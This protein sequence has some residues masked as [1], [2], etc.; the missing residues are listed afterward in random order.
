MQ[1]KSEN[2]Q[3]KWRRVSPSLLY[4]SLILSLFSLSKAIL[5]IK[6]PNI[7]SDLLSESLEQLSILSLL[8]L[9]V[10]SSEINNES[11]DF[12]LTDIWADNIFLYIVLYILLYS[13]FVSLKYPYIF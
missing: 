10:L 1:L 2:L 9:F 7:A 3:A 6:F 5:E 4:L 12:K 8:L 11:F 13:S